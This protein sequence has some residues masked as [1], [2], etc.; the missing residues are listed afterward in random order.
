MGRPARGG[1]EEG[2]KDD[3]SYCRA[4]ATADRRRRSATMRS[5]SRPGWSPS[6]RTAPSWCASGDTVVLATAVGRTEGREGADFFPLTV[7]IEEKMYAAGQDPRR[8]LQAGGSR[9]REGDPDLPHGRPADPA[10]VAEGLQERGAGH[11]HRPLGRPGASARHPRDQRRLRSADALAA[12][13]SWARSARCASAQHR[14][15]AGRQP[16]AARA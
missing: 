14:R 3:M 13:P 8:F 10:A 6:R 2:T 15:R 16:D 7:D 1:P 12:C 11:R 4:R 5:R 9:R